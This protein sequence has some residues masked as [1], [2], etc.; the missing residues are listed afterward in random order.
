MASSDEL[1]ERIAKIEGYKKGST[2]IG[3]QWTKPNGTPIP[4]LPSWSTSLDL[5]DQ[6]HEGE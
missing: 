6:I 3:F 5:F 4:M 2:K 1:N